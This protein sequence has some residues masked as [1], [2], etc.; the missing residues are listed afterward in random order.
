MIYYEIIRKSD[1]IKFAIQ[2]SRPPDGA[3]KTKLFD[4]HVVDCEGYPEFEFDDDGNPISEASPE[5]TL[6]KDYI[7][8]KEKITKL[9]TEVATL[10]TKVA[11]LEA[12][13]SAQVLRK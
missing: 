3:Y 1:G 8:D 2:N 11:I 12:T 10:K 13:A 7:S 9:E 6:L 4:I 5:F